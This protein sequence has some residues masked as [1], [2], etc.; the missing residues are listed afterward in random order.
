MGSLLL[1]IKGNRQAKHHDFRNKVEGKAALEVDCAFLSW[2]IMVLQWFEESVAS[3]PWI[4]AKPL[5]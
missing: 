5:G 3:V 2:E 4:M 1:L